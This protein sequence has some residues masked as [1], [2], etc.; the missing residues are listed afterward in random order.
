MSTIATPHSTVMPGLVPGIHDHSQQRW[1]SWITGTN[2]AMTGWGCGSGGATKDPEA[3]GYYVYIL[4]S[5][6]HGTLYIGV[7]NDLIRRGW[8][9]R[10]GLADGFTKKHGVK[11]LAW[12]EQHEDVTAAIQREKT[13]K[14]WP[15]DWKINLIEQSN[16]E[17]LDLYDQLASGA[18]KEWS[19]E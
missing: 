11:R 2:P 13:M 15:R 12:F 19:G 16:P 5:R 18:D 10:E 6:R 3:M 17:W 7:T 9:H 1:C 8:E 4:A 14:G